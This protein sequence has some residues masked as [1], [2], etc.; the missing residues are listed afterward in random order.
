MPHNL[1]DDEAVELAAEFTKRLN[2]SQAMLGISISKLREEM[3]ARVEKLELK[4]AGEL[5]ALDVP[6]NV[7]KRLAKLEADV[8]KLKYDHSAP[9]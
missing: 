9:F 4:L 2:V 6:I 5:V 1:T 7:E 3:N 8:E